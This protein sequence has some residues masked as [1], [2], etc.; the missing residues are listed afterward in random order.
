MKKILAFLLLSLIVSTS[1]LAQTPKSQ[2]TNKPVSMQPDSKLNP[3]GPMDSK[4]LPI[5]VDE[6]EEPVTLDD[7]AK[8]RT[9]FT[10]AE[11]EARSEAAYNLIHDKKVSEHLANLRNKKESILV[12]LR[13]ND[14]LQP[15]YDVEV[16]NFFD[17]LADRKFDEGSLS[18]GL[19]SL[20][21]ENELESIR[22]NLNN[23]PQELQPRLGMIF[24]QFIM[25]EAPIL[26]AQSLKL[27]DKRECFEKS[28]FE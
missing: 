7:I 3:S 22:Q 28:N 23:P 25:N 13:N 6:E 8:P 12:K 9:K 18:Y 14:C 21:N 4:E 16:G 24:I 15:G 11:F 10:A 27:K 19:A 20:F 5:A 26:F 17:K 1:A 2:Q